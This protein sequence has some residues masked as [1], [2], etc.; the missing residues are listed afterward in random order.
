MHRIRVVKAVVRRGDAE[1]RAVRIR[2]KSQREAANSANDRAVLQHGVRGT[3]HHVHLR[4]APRHRRRLQQPHRHPRRSHAARCLVAVS[5]RTALCHDEREVSLARCAAEQLGEARAGSKREH[6]SG[7]AAA[8]P[9]AAK[10][11]LQL[12]RA[13]ARE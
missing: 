3:Q 4:H 1:W 7:A 11:L 8:D 13:D 9:E 5:C 10:H 6:A 2:H 12:L